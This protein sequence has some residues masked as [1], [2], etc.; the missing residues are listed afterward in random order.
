MCVISV[1]VPIYNEERYLDRCVQSIIR[2]TFHDME[3]ILVDDGST[4]ESGRLCDELSKRD[5]RIKVLHKEN[6]GLSS[7][8]NAGIDKAAGKYIG[9][10]DADDWIID[11][12][13]EYMV[14]QMEECNVDIVSV[15]YAL[16]R[17]DKEVKAGKD[18]IRVMQRSEAL[19]YY[20]YIGMKSIISDYSVCI[21]LY[22]KKL[23]DDVRFPD[24][25][26]YEDIVTNYKLISKTNKYLKSDKVCYYYFQNPESIVHDKFKMKDLYIIDIG[27]EL[28]ELAREENNSKLMR[29]AKMKKARGY[30]SCL[31]KMIVYGWDSS[32]ENMG[33]IINDLL[34]GVRRNYLLL[35]TSPMSAN[36]KMIVGIQCLFRGWIKKIILRKNNEKQ[37]T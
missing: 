15:S 36:R 23:F 19:E 20:T 32:I 1:I 34:N 16:A 6:G 17:G 5:E 24:G 26:L 9:F 25:K 29:L 7:A 21:K 22:K 37:I 35:F 18:R 3:I 8:R 13:Y 2:Q 4:D 10:V 11:T 14:K 28:I 12:M 31:M 27:E 30:F 33:E